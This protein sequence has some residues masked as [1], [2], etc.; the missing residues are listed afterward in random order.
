MRPIHRRTFLARSFQATTAVTLAGLSGRRV[1]GANDQPNV[2]M[3]GCGGRGT[4]V[5]RGIAGA[6]ARITWLCDLDS[7]RSA[8]VAGFLERYAPDTKASNIR[9]TREMRELLEDGSLDAVIVATPDHWH[10]LA[11]LRCVQAGK[12]VYVEKPHSHDIYESQLMRDAAR[13]TGR[14]IQ[15]GT[16]NRSGAYNL[17]ALD[18]IRSGKLGDI[19]LVKVFNLKS[20]GPFQLGDPGEPP[21]GFSWNDW[22]GPAAERPFH[23]RIFHGGWHHFW[24]YSGGDLCDD[25]AHQMDLALMLMGDPGMPRTV[26]SAGGRLAHPGDDSQVPDVLVSTFEFDGFILTL[27]HS[28]YPKYMTKTTTTIRQSDEFPFW[29]HNA[30]RIELYGSEQM[31]VVGRHGGGWQATI[32][33][34]E[35][36]AQ[37]FGRPCDDEHYANFLECVKTRKHPNAYIEKLHPSVCMLHMANIAHRVGNRK[38]QFD[39]EREQFDS[40]EA[41]QLVRIPPRRGFEMP[42]IG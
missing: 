3:I 15:V 23:Q 11:T 31:M 29:M 4:Y 34:W 28:N 21:A 9:Q 10:A 7:T 1:W 24:E 13:K 12:D 35:I 32:Y 5:S 16:Q 17:K 25:A 38:L 22:Q 14:L 6:G 33:P 27:E 20:G 18:Y 26:A 30:T 42:T 2:G 37:E 39:A 40:P 8:G 36:M 19:H 41:N